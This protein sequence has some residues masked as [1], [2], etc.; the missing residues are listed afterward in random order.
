M[1]DIYSSAAKVV[2]YLGQPTEQTE[3]G[4]SNLQ[5]IMQD[6]DHAPSWSTVPLAQLEES[7]KD[8]IC[9]EW[10]EGMWTVQEAALARSTTLQCGHYKLYWRG[11][12]R[13][14]RAMVFRIKT[15]AI[16][17]YYTLSSGR[18]STLDWSPLLDI[19][20]T[21]LRQA[22]RREGKALQRTTLDLA[23][24]FRDRITTV[25][26]DRYLAI[27]AVIENDDGARLKFRPDYTL[28]LEEIYHQFVV[29]I[30]SINGIGDVALNNEL[31]FD[32]RAAGKCREDK[33]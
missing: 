16:S 5:S 15:A 23:F 13:T 20:E 24:D 12:L 22:S 3:A 27:L 17:P 2:V 30:Q 7:I 28:P 26:Q 25:P 1:G 18:R 4:M 33:L 14:V 21:Q 19:L 32:L 31:F 8:I 11:N 6:S 9:R 29:E 10:F